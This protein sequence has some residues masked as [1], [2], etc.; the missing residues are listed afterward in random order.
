[1][2]IRDRCDILIGHCAVLASSACFLASTIA[3]FRFSSGLR[4]ASFC[5]SWPT[6]AIIAKQRS[7]HLCK[8]WFNDIGFLAIFDFRFAHFDLRFAICDFAVRC[9]LSGRLAE[10]SAKPYLRR[11]SVAFSK[12]FGVVPNASA[13]RSSILL[14]HTYQTGPENVFQVLH[15]G[16]QRVDQMILIDLNPNITQLLSKFL[17]DKTTSARNYLTV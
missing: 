15:D 1:V 8:G 3:C 7:R 16:R 14:W 9:A 4:Q 11:A 17:N 12:R 13:C 5:R 6:R 10:C 2:N